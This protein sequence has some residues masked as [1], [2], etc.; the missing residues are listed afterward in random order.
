VKQFKQLTLIVASLLVVTFSFSFAK[1]VDS[2]ASLQKKS[3]EC[4]FTVLTD[5]DID[6]DLTG[7][8]LNVSYACCFFEPIHWELNL[9]G[10]IQSAS[11]ALPASTSYYLKIRSIRI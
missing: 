3:V 9:I 5:D 4:H 1:P 6:E 8:E 11:E 2:S 7:P 10:N